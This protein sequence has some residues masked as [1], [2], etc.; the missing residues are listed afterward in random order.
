[1]R[2]SRQAFNTCRQSIHTTVRF[3]DHGQP[4]HNVNISVIVCLI[5]Q[6]QSYLFDH[7][8]RSDHGKNRYDRQLVPH[9]HKVRL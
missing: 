4:K 1:M 3:K 2:V 7:D 9:K 8:D 5:Q 6:K